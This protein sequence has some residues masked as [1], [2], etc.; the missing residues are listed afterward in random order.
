MSEIP[1]IDNNHPLW[2]QWF[3]YFIE[4]VL[5]L[6]VFIFAMLAKAWGLFKNKT[7]MTRIEIFMDM[8]LTGLGSAIIIYCLC[9]IN[10]PTW[11]FCLCGGYS[12]TLVTPIATVLSREAAPFVELCVKLVEEKIIKWFKKK[13]K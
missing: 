6:C 9:H 3:N 5:I 10:M 1:R 7:E 13:D 12:S 2:E 11:M 8:A 4:R